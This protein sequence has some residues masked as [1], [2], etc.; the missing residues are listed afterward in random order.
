MPLTTLIILTVIL[1]L[2]IFFSA[3]SSALEAAYSF[4]NPISLKQGLVKNSFTWKIVKKHHL[5]FGRTLSTI[6][7][8][9]NIINIAAS[10]LL[11]FILSKTLIDDSWNVIIS[12]VIMTPL[13]VVFGEILPKIFARKYPIQYIKRVAWLMELFYWLFL[14]LTFPLAKLLKSSEVTNTEKELRTIIKL[15]YE[16]GILEKKES[17][18]ALNALDMDSIKLRQH[19][20]KLKDV[21]YVNF[22]WDLKQVK[23]KFLETGYSRLP[24][25]KNNRF[26]GI[27]ILKDIWFQKSGIAK[28]FVV[29][30]PSISS[31]ILIT[32][33]LNKMRIEKAQFAFVVKNQNSRL[34]IGIVTFEDI[35]EELIGEIY[36]EHDEE[37]DIY[38]VAL[39]HAIISG[40]T[41]ISKINQILKFKLPDV[42]MQLGQWLKFQTEKELTLN[43]KYVYKNYTFK[44]VQN[45]RNCHPKI[46]V[47]QK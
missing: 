41:K 37:V 7:L 10:T 9:N 34:P 11:S 31:N 39:N 38:E 24:I 18:L 22:D 14:P 47:Y 16:E 1:V 6:L 27:I 33:A 19:Y 45:K 28:D 3:I 44:V 13:I 35:L 36:D 17:I 29:E 23:A 2:L 40:H 15:G 5:F 20:T 46:D 32:K 42:E 25:K 43:F 8:A 4:I 30:V 12:I 21:D 26:I